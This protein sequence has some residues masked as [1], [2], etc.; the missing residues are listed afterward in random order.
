M[1][2]GCGRV[3]IGASRIKFAVGYARAAWVQ[4]EERAGFALDTR[5][6]PAAEAAA[7]DRTCIYLLLRGRWVLHGD[8]SFEGPSAFVVSEELLEGANGARSRTFCS[9]GSPLVSIELHLPTTYVLAGAG[10]PSALAM[11]EDAWAAA[12]EFSAALEGEHPA[13]LLRERLPRLLREL[14]RLAILTP[15]APAV[16]G[17]PAP[18]ALE[19]VL[20]AMLRSVERMYLGGTMKDLESATGISQ[21]QLARDIES[22]VRVIGLVGLGWRLTSRHLRIKIAVMLLSGEHATVAGVA[23]IVGWGSADAM[24]RAFRNS[25]LAAPTVVQRQ[26]RASS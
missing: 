12:F 16:I 5:F 18:A 22:A 6:I 1:Q 17:E 19:R 3:A 23:R 10:V 2:F 7:P 8:C 15:D 11:D 26:V 9:A 24:T 25:G 13:T 4:V 21:R 14:S 20:R